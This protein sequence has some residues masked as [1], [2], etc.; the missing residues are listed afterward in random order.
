MGATASKARRRNYV[1]VDDSNK[2]NG[3]AAPRNYV[4]VALGLF[5]FE[6]CPSSGRAFFRKYPIVEVALLPTPFE[7]NDSY[8]SH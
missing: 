7:T 2:A 5:F 6:L 1:H 8:M 4:I 3:H